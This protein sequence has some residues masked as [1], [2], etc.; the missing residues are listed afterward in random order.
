MQWASPC[1]RPRRWCVKGARVVPCGEQRLI[2]TKLLVAQ[3]LRRWTCTRSYT[4][5]CNLEHVVAVNDVA[6][7]QT[8]RWN[9]WNLQC[10]VIP[11]SS[12]SGLDH[13]G[14]LARR[15]ADRTKSGFRSIRAYSSI[16]HE[17]H[18][19]YINKNTQLTYFTPPR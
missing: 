6:A 9:C 1:G 5:L 14:T 10:N 11:R 4:E 7:S 13:A 15:H 2:T 19:L 16:S 18:I 12:C 3:S 17:L 8:W